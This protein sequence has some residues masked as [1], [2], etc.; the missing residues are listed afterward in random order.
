MNDA[1]DTKSYA[2]GILTDVVMGVAVVEYLERID[3]TLEP[4]GGHFLIHGAQST[5]HEGTEPGTL[6]LIEFP[7]TTGAASW[8]QSDAYQAIIALR[9]DNS[10]ST[11][12]TI[13]GVPDGH[14]ATD[15]LTTG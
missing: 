11:I 4:F 6:V 1:V 9:A 14:L 15:I 5:L 3:A 2:I 12:L 10:N 8:Y 13:E 7:S